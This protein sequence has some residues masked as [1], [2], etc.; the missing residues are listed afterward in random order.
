M[1]RKTW[2]FR[3]VKRLTM[4]P[5]LQ[6]GIA[7]S[8]CRTV[9]STWARCVR[10][11][12]GCRACSSSV[13]YMTDRP[14]ASDSRLSRLSFSSGLV[15][16]PHWITPVPTSRK[17]SARANSSD[18]GAQAAG[19][20]LP[21]MSKWFML[22][23]I[24]S[25]S[26][27]ASSASRTTPRMTSS[28][29]SVAGRSEHSSPIAKRRTAEWPTSVPTF[30]AE[31]APDRRHVLGERLPGPRHPG[32]EDVHRDR[33]DVGEHPGQPLAS[34]GPHRGQ[35]QRAV[36]DDDGG[37]AVMAGVGA[38]RIPE[39]L[40]VVVAVIVDEARRDDPPVGLDHLAGGAARGARAPRSCRRPRRHRRGRR[41]ARSRR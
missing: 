4:L 6:R 38:Q 22:R 36:A 14:Q 18:S 40:R 2:Q 35:S 1:L 13:L 27:P 28:S 30:T 12:P 21:A 3:I 41:A 11:R 33:L 32:V 31:P 8:P 15:P 26:A 10:H 9:S 24:E 37:R 34:L 5:G 7:R 29:A 39:D 19:M 17:T 23:V 25:P 20:R 16:P